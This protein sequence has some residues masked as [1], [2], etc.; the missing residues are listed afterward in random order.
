MNRQQN[1]RKNP[2][3]ARFLQTFHS[4]I[5]STGR[6]YRQEMGVETEER[7]ALDFVSGQ[8]N[9]RGNQ[10][11]AEIAGHQVKLGEGL[12]S[13]KQA[14]WIID[15]ATTRETP[16]PAEAVL[17][18]LEQGFA[19][20]AGSAFITNYKDLPRKARSAS[21]A[22]I[23]AVAPCASDEEY[24]AAYPAV[25]EG[26]Y[27]IQM[28]DQ[29]KPHFYRIVHGRKP[30]VIFVNEQASDET[31][32]VRNRAA[33]EAILAEISKNVDKAGMAYATLLGSCRACGRTLTDH[34]NPYFSIGLGPECGK[35]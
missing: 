10:Y 1:F 22:E 27:A 17:I 3:T 29:D 34:H 25:P 2:H 18:R 24:A 9:L 28:Q 15:I 19:K 8:A 30:G 12:V 23:E 6:N 11:M 5:G 35:K 26:R 16:G 32:P 4:G 13:E 14:K 31:Y 21:A 20:A 7:A 33:R